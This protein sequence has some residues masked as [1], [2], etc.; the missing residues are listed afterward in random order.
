MDKASENKLSVFSSKFLEIR[1]GGKKKAKEPKKK[2]QKSL[3]P[4][5][6]R[7][8][9]RNT[10]F[11]FHV[12]SLFFWNLEQ[13]ERARG[14]KTDHLFQ[15]IQL[16]LTETFRFLYTIVDSKS[17]EMF[18]NFPNFCPLKHTV[19][20]GFPQKVFV[21]TKVCKLHHKVCVDK[22]ITKPEGFSVDNS[23]TYCLFYEA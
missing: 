1:R 8:K 5:Y 20:T 22:C 4:Q 9:T 14:L 7:Q 13:N 16:L 19:L 23:Q 18:A 2:Q 6:F 10:I 21:Y 3:F 11:C 15:Y 12:F 17:W